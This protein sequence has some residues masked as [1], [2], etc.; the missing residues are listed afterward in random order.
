MSEKTCAVCGKVLEPDEVRLN[1]RSYQRAE[2]W[3]GQAEIKISVQELSEE[4]IQQLH[5]VDKK[6]DRENNL[7]S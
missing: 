3:G 5:R 6:A 7:G 2:L 4:G 1:E